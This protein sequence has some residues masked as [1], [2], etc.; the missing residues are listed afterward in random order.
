MSAWR[1]SYAGA[2]LK[3][4]LAGLRKRLHGVAPAL[5]HLKA[6]APEVRV[7]LEARYWVLRGKG[8]E[9]VTELLGRS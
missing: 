8:A 7:R 6:S 5:H 9:K 3:V 4:K 1:R 2:G